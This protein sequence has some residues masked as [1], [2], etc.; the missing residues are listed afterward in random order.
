MG[1]LNII[2]SVMARISAAIAAHTAAVDPHGDRAYV[3]A[4][5]PAYKVYSAIVSQAGNQA[6]VATVFQNN[7]GG[8]VV[9][10]RWSVGVY[11]ATLEGAFPYDKTQIMIGT[12]LQGGTFVQMSTNEEDPD[13]I[14]IESYNS[15]QQYSDNILISMSIEIRIYE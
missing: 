3:D 6:P 14:T 4:R 13:A 9:W 10:S 5:L 2:Q 8:P 11:Y 12:P 1:G 15:A 7:L